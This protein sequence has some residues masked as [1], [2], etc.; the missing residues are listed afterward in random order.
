MCHIQVLVQL[1]RDFDELGVHYP[2]FTI[3]NTELLVILHDEE[4]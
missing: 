4:T 3:W 1:K 2:V